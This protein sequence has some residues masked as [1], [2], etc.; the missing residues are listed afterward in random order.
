MSALSSAW[1]RASAGVEL[2]TQARQELSSPEEEVE[3]KRKKQ[4]CRG[5]PGTREASLVHL[6]IYF[7]C[8]VLYQALFLASVNKEG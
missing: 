6:S 3:V 5:Q 7:L 8:T 1:G 4:V 2:G